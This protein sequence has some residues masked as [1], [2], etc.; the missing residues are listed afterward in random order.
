MRHGAGLRTTILWGAFCAVLAIAPAAAFDA[1]VIVT[2]ETTTSGIAGDT[3]VLGQSVVTQAWTDLV[4]GENGGLS[5]QGS[6]RYAAGTDPYVNLDELALDLSFDVGGAGVTRITAGRF[7]FDDATGL[8]FSDPADGLR[9]GTLFPSL[10]ASLSVGYTGLT[11]SR[12]STVTLSRADDLSDDSLAPPRLFLD[13]RA[14]LL[15]VLGRQNVTFGASGQL[16]FRPQSEVVEAGDP[17][18]AAD[19]EGPGGRVH[20]AYG[21]LLAS[22][23]IAAGLYYDAFAV[24]NVGRVLT[25]VDGAYAESTILAGLFGGS[26]ELFIPA[27]VQPT[28]ALSGLFATG[29]E[30]SEFTY[31]GNT[32]GRSE[33]FEPISA[34]NLGFIASP[35]IQNLLLGQLD[36]SITP[37]A[38]SQSRF[39]RLLGVTASGTVFGRPTTGVA[40]L[41]NVEAFAESLYIGS[42]ASLRIDARLVSDFGITLQGGAF[43]PNPDVFV[44][45]GIRFRGSLGA[46]FSF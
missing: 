13:A 22:G 1:G 23:P 4:V 21:T 27:T 31:E 39:L 11:L 38:G 7:V 19:T 35:R 12:V 34:P 15:E 6:F 9:V 43:F 37:F 17:A 41:S 5:A 42:E 40:T 46:A 29:D 20:T 26:I 28:I 8:V 36:A 16:D 10:D 44:D 30:D 32:A 24:L 3:A 45:D 18:S 14:T 25:L 2:S 33:G